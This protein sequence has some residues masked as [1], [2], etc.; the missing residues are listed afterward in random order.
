VAA[1]TRIAEADG[2]RPGLS[3]ARREALWALKALRD[4]PLPLFAAAS[5]REAQ[6]VPDVDERPASLRPMTAGGEVVEDYRH[7]S[8]SLRS[9]P[10]SFLREDL[11]GRK[12]VRCVEAMEA[13]DGRW[14]EAAGIVLVRQRPGSAKGVMFITLEDESGIANLVVWPKVFEQHRRTILTATMV[15]VRRGG[16]SRGA[17]IHRSVGRPRARRSVGRELPAAAWPWGRIP[18]RAAGAR[19]KEHA[20]GSCAGTRH[21][22]SR[23]PL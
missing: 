14:L 9:H 21:L 2:F 5:A 10:V 11:R 17:K 13:R 7:L 18:P 20:D 22:C 15:A 12:V 8:L 16:S 6:V 1:L 19:S 3:L 4:E 23:P